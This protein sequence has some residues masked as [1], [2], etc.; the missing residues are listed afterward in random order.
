MEWITRAGG[1]VE[2]KRYI[3]GFLILTETGP[4]A[5]PARQY[6]YVFPDHLG[7]LDTLVDQNGLVQERMSFDA[8]GSRRAA[9][10]S[11]IWQTLINN[12]APANTTRG[13]TGQEHVDRAGIVHMNGRLYD[14]LLGRMLSADPIAQEPENAQNL[15]RYTYVLNNPLSYTDPTGLSFFKKYWRSIVSI[16]INIFLPGAGWFI[17]AFGNGIAGAMVAGFL[18]GVVGSGNLQGGLI[19]AFSAGVFFGIGEKFQ[20]IA[21]ANKGAGLKALNGL[22]P[23]QFAAKVLAHGTAGG[24][25]STLQ[26]GKFG[27]GFASAGVAQAFAPAIDGIGGRANAYAPARI[28]AASLVGGTSSVLSGGKFANGAVTA[29]FSR[30][31]N[32]EPHFDGETLKW[33]DDDGNVVEQYDAVSGRVGYQSPTLQNETDKGPI[34]EGLFL[35]SQED[36]QESSDMPM[37]RRVASYNPFFKT[38]AWPGGTPAWGNQRI[39]LKPIQGEMYGRDA[40]SIHGGDYPG[41]AGCID[42]TF[43]MPSFATRFRDYGSDMWLHVNFS[44]Q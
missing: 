29:A 1:T 44:K 4:Q 32:D 38:T 41:S 20:T 21:N 33:V 31:F 22:K 10:G 3:G 35:V 39:W 30:A 16:A 7:S 40:F 5:T 13:F 8:H 17:A 37:S 18:S 34:P 14:P 27:H 12:P 19:G 43:R 23:H 36:Y 25:M 24:V 26:G 9:T 6:R 2:R 15:N 28:L 42:L 11:G